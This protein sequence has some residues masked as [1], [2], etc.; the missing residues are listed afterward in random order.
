M[1]AHN[2]NTQVKVTLNDLGDAILLDKDTSASSLVKM[3][4][5]RR[6]QQ[7]ENW[8]PTSNSSGTAQSCTSKLHLFYSEKDR[9]LF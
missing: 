1:S 2:T 4:R 9:F 6:N 8:R 7:Q 5:Q 3:L